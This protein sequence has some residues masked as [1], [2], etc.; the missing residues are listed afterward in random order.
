MFANKVDADKFVLDLMQNQEQPP[1]TVIRRVSRYIIVIYH[2]LV[3]LL[4]FFPFVRF[5]LLPTQCFCA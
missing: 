4:Y 1:F 2:L 3:C 5:L